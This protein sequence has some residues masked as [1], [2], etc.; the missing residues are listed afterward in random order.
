MCRPSG[1]SLPRLHD[2][3]SLPAFHKIYVNVARNFN[4]LPCP[5]PFC[6]AIIFKFY[7][8]DN[9]LLSLEEAAL[10]PS[11]GASRDFNAY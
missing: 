9:V 10:D 3:F 7:C 1:I 11:I 2:R 5:L 4:K 8:L 6:V